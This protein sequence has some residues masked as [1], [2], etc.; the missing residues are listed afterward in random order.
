MCTSTFSFLFFLKHGCKLRQKE[1]HMPNQDGDLLSQ[2]LRTLQIIRDLDR[3]AG[4]DKYELSDRYGVSLRTIERTLS[5]IQQAGLPLVREQHERRSLWRIAY[6]DKLSKLS[7]LLD[8]SHYLALRMAMGQGGPSRA[9]SAQFAAL[10]DLADKIES[11]LGKKE[12]EQLQS[13]DDCFHSYEKFSYHRAPRDVLWS[14]VQA[15]G[16]RRLCKL[17][18]TAAQVEAS[19]RMLQVLPLKLF[20]H[21][22]ALYLL[23]HVVKHAN[24]TTLN[25]Q[26][27]NSLKV[28]DKTGEPPPDFDIEA[29]E[30]KAFRLVANAPEVTYRLKFTPQIAVYIRERE[31]H[32]GQELVELEDGGVELT[33]TCAGTYEVASWVA[34]WRKGVE[35]L[36]PESLRQELCD[37]GEWLSDTYAESST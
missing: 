31:W 29:W 34:S 30:R 33:F 4:V 5:V 20:V 23:C 15:I 17:S 14:L 7:S 10:E 16:G 6:R 37:L 3:L 21:D 2:L 36:E 24:V 35:V 12:R 22:A 1:S 28:L 25:L 9:L 13:I 32:P 26:R 11:T 19:P 27:I 18:Y 8:V